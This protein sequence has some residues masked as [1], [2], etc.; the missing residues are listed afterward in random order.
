MRTVTLHSAIS[1]DRQLAYLFI[2]EDI[3]LVVA[4]GGRQVANEIIVAFRFQNSTEYNTLTKAFAKLR[5]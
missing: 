2:S 5:K 1:F 4:V 3:E